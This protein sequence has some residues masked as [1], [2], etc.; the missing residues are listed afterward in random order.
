MVNS[1]YRMRIRRSVL[2]L[3]FVTFVWN[4]N[5]QMK[6]YNPQKAE[7]SVMQNQAWSD[8]IGFTFTRLPQRAEQLV[9]KPVWDLSRNS[10]GLAIY[11]YTNASEITVRYGVEGALNMPHMPTLGVSGLDM[12]RVDDNKEQAFCYG[13]YAFK[14]TVTYSYSGLDVNSTNPRGYEY[15]L[16]LPLYNR[17]KW[18]EIGVPES[19]E[20]SFIPL[21]SEKP[22]VL[23]GTSIAQGACASRPGMAWGNIVQ[24]SLDVPLVNLGFSGNGRLE[25]E[26]LDFI[27]EIDARLYILDCLPNLAGE[28]E[29][30]LYDIIVNAVTRLREKAATPILMIEHLGA[31]YSGVN[32]EK[33]EEDAKVN[34]ASK[35][36]Y[37]ALRE[38]G[39]KDLF[40]LTKEELNISSDGWVDYIHPTDLGMQAQADAVI[41][42]VKEI[43]KD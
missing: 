37:A 26:V 5:A 42:K 27:G 43:L 35:K 18:L 19:A 22:I 30:K 24:R 25:K 16:Y 3:L 41:K 31:S 32:K 40:Y 1:S 12:Y 4:S 38:A 23:Y 34:N 11:F 6:W 39:I 21:S 28:E 13:K 7:K 20:L 10:A 9:R 17:V 8:E 2:L 14:D 15:R 29:G 36:A 33:R